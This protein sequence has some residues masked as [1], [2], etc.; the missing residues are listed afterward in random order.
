MDLRFRRLAITALA[1]LA[2]LA[3]WG[4]QSGGETKDEQ[5]QS[6]NKPVKQEPQGPKVTGALDSQPI[7]GLGFQRAVLSL[8]VKP[9]GEVS[10]VFQGG[11]DDKPFEVFVTGEVGSDGTLLATGE[12]TDG[13]LRI[14]GP[15]EANGFSGE[16]TGEIF[17]EEF[18]L[19]MALEPGKE[20]A[21]EVEEEQD[22]E[23]VQ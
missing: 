2:A 8:D 16:V 11:Y 13:T 23:P 12:G 1:L 9:G 6:A 7:S 19:P 10:G 3:L 17:T 21:A 4:C 15:L 22:V 18:S 20:R 5:A 14:E